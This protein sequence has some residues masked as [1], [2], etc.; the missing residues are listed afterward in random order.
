MCVYVEVF[1]WKE[2]FST[3]SVVSKEFPRFKMPLYEHQ[4]RCRGGWVC[5]CKGEAN[6][7]QTFTGGGGVSESLNEG[8]LAGKDADGFLPSAPSFQRHCPWRAMEA[9]CSACT[10]PVSA[11]RWGQPQPVQ[12]SEA[13][14]RQRERTFRPSQ[15]EPCT[16]LFCGVLFST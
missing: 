16:S 11:R 4:N 6:G 2:V 9:R 10:S 1:E 8:E 5:G 7:F 14:G 12:V 15:K 13:S 3:L